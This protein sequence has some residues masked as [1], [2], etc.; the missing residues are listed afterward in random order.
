[1]NLILNQLYLHLFFPLLPNI[2]RKSLFCRLFHKIFNYVF[3]WNFAAT[4]V[5]FLQMRVRVKS[6]K[7]QQE[8]QIN[9]ILA[10]IH[11]ICPPPKNHVFYTLSIYIYLI[12]VGM[13]I[14]DPTCIYL[15]VTKRKAHP[16]VL[17][18]SNFVHRADGIFALSSHRLCTIR[19]VHKFV[20]KTTIHQKLN[21]KETT[22][23]PPRKFL[24][25]L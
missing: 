15:F 25:L 9:L 1:M 24:P 11:N 22:L 19:R 10:R 2:N 23:M 6:A 3:I 13:Y 20:P 8:Q 7:Q 4:S 16:H 12:Y 18:C 17:L 21:K 5:Q 14:V